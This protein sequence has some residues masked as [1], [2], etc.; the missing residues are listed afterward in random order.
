M[1]KNDTLEVE[2]EATRVE[3]YRLRAVAHGRDQQLAAL[4]TENATL[5]ARVAELERGTVL[6]TADVRRRAAAAEA[7]VEKLRTELGMLSGRSEGTRQQIRAMRGLPCDCATCPSCTENARLR[8]ALA[9]ADGALRQVQRDV[10]KAGRFLE[11]DPPG[12]TSALKHVEHAARCIE[13]AYRVA[14]DLNAAPC[15]PGAALAGKE[16]DS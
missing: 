8:A 5:K 16:G 7:E 6:D 11:A 10:M 4:I 15:D 9:V 3:L 2:A 14:S 13:S 12:P 1:A